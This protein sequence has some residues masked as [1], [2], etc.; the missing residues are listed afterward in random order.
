MPNL[1]IAGENAAPDTATAVENVA[2]FAATPAQH[3]CEIAR[4]DP[5]EL[6][7]ADLGRGE[8]ERTDRATRRRDA[9]IGQVG[10]RAHDELRAVGGV[11]VDG[12]L[13]IEVDG[14]DGIRRGT[15]DGKRAAESTLVVRV[16]R[17]RHEIGH[18]E[19]PD[20]GG[21]HHEP[22]EPLGGDVAAE[23]G[24]VAARPALCGTCQQI[25]R[26]ERRH[27]R[28]DKPCGQRHDRTTRSL[29][30]GAQR[31]AQHRDKSER[32][33]EPHRIDGAAGGFAVVGDAVECEPPERVGERAVA[34]W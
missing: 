1:P 4:V 7:V 13:A 14:L 16:Q 12:V 22:N 28:H 19:E 6:A 23:D 11:L 27:Q 31:G 20:K 18:R 29:E 10:R 24:E 17:P 2:S 15:T 30:H 32:L 26:G 3:D 5:S 25:D 21:E 8:R 34:R 33:E 9:A